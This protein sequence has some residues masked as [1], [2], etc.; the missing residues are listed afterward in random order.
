ME[1]L[2]AAGINYKM[3]VFNAKYI[4][5]IQ[6]K[7]VLYMKYLRVSTMLDK[8]TSS[9]SNKLLQNGIFTW[10]YVERDNVFLWPQIHLIYSFPCATTEPA[11]LFAFVAIP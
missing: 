5:V 3:F 4:K 6:L 1:Y 8:Y 11:V 2:K 7:F 10:T 9:S